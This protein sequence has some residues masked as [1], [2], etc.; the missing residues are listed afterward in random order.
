MDTLLL[1]S[2]TVGLFV[3][4]PLGVGFLVKR[5]FAACAVW[6]ALTGLMAVSQSTDDHD[7]IFWVFVVAVGLAALPLVLVGTRVR[8]RG[9]ARRASSAHPR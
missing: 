2:W 5:Q 9:A 3:L 6:V 7:G 1:I 8:S 4:L